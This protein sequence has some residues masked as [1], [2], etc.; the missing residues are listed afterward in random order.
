MRLFDALVL[1]E[2]ATMSAR[3]TR[4]TTRP[5]AIAAACY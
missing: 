2:R 5:R 3:K 1:V 4:A